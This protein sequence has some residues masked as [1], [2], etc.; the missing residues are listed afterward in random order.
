MT[1]GRRLAILVMLITAI[2]AGIL[3]GIW[4]FDEVTG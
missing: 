2:A 4:L 1:D 3:L